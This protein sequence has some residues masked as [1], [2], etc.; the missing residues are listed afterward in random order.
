MNEIIKIVEREGRQTVDARDLHE[1]LESGQKFSDWIKSRIDDFDFIDEIDYILILGKTS[2]K[3]GRP[4]KDYFL[5]IEMAKELSML[6]RNDKGKQAR[7]YFIECEKKLK[8]VPILSMEDMMI[9][10]LQNMKAVKEQVNLIEDKINEIKSNQFE[11]VEDIKRLPEP[12]EQIDPTTTRK[13]ITRL[14]RSYCL[15]SSSSFQQAYNDLYT[16]VKYRL[17]KDLKKRSKNAGNK[18]L[19]IAEELGLIEQV[20]SLA[21]ELFGE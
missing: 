7:K 5:S 9:A 8:E 12:I 6:E 21:L 16:E 1:F 15:N 3:G 11:A 17:S 20:Y 19:D 18:P 2:N 14:I 10:Q 13:N 4:S